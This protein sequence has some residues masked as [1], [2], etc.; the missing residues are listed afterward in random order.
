MYFIIIFND[1]LIKSHTL[2]LS[3]LS[4]C[5]YKTRFNLLFIFAFTSHDFPV[6]KRSSLDSVM[7]F[8]IFVGLVVAV[9]GLIYYWFNKKFSYWEKR[10]FEYVKPE[11]PFGSMSGVGYKVH[12]SEKSRAFYNEFRSK[13]KAVGLYFFTAPVI[14]ITNL[15]LLKHIL[16]KDFN[17]FH[18][19]GL[20]VNTKADPLSGHL[21]ALEGEF[22]IS[23]KSDLFLN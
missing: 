17:S 18:D 22:K 11:F 10:G 19:R 6:L 2:N 1:E 23:S 15:D 4:L 8:N 12:F 21:F 20:Y 5:L 3:E 9:V 16:V 7:G 13:A 14:L